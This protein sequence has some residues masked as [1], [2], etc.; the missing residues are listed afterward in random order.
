M[1]PSGQDA[2]LQGVHLLF[3]LPDIFTTTCLSHSLPSELMDSRCDT[4][5]L[6]PSPSRRTLLLEWHHMGVFLHSARFPHWFAW[7]ALVEKTNTVISKERLLLDQSR[8]P[9]LQRDGWS[10]YW[11]LSCCLYYFAVEF[12]GLNEAKGEYIFFSCTL[13]PQSIRLLR[14]I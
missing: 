12:P 5:P 1:A 13:E 9:F 7:L 2:G 4:L 8:F 3:P 14:D 10:Y 6:S 11:C